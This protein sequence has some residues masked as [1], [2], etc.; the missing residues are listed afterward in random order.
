MPDERIESTRAALPAALGVM[1]RHGRMFALAFGILLLCACREGSPIVSGEVQAQDAG[2][3]SLN[4]RQVQ[5]LNT[6]LEEHH[7]GWSQLVLATP[8]PTSSLSV[9]VRRERGESGRIE[10][11]SQEGWKAALMYWGREARD[12]RQGSFPADDVRTLREELEKTQ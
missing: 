12:N 5:F 4:A 6:W 2:S 10:F 7:S 1:K 3:R 9:T 8:P 11:Y